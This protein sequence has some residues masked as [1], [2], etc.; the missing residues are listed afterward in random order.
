MQEHSTTRTRVWDL[1]VRIF[2]WAL[3]ASFAGAYLLA[4]SERWR[5]VH[6]TLGYTVLGLLAFRIVWGFIGTHHAR[7]KSF[8][9]SPL[10]ALRYLRDELVG[11]GRRYLGH[12]PAGSWAVYGL[13]L[14]GTAS[15]VTGF[16]TFNEIGGD[17]FEEA[18]EA[19]AN[20]WLALVVLHVLGVI[21]SSAMQRENLA[22]AMFTGYKGG[23]ADD[24]DVRPL[25]GLGVTLAAAVLGFWTWNLAWI[26]PVA[27]DPA[28]TRPGAAGLSEL[29]EELESD[30]D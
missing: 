4:D 8:A 22:R 21:F 7:F 16:L 25:R 27:G 19:F 18:H 28:S 6:V 5:A 29:D 14:L 12:N 13:L 24:R 17:V 9:Y 2:H 23:A 15:G 3:G 20:A 11:R 26:A 10:A 1:P 30:D